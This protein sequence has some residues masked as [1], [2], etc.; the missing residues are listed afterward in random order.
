MYWKILLIVH[1]AFSPSKNIYGNLSGNCS[2]LLSFA[3]A[4]QLLFHQIVGV[5][6]HRDPLIFYDSKSD[7]FFS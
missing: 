1:K 2:L 3:I 4:S 7:I 6:T 5:T